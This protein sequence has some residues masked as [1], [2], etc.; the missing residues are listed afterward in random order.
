MEDN[1]KILNIDYYSLVN[2]TFWKLLKWFLDCVLN[3]GGDFGKINTI[4]LPGGRGSGKSM[5]VTLL[6]FIGLLHLKRPSITVMKHENKLRETIYAA[7]EKMAR[8]MGILDLVDFISRPLEIRLKTNEKKSKLKLKFF[9]VDKSTGLKSLEDAS[10]EGVFIVHIDEADQIDSQEDLDNILASV[11]G[12]KFLTI[13]TYNPPKSIN[14]WIHELETPTNDRIVVW[15]DYLT[16]PVDWLQPTFIQIAERMRDSTSEKRRRNYRW[17]YLGQRVSTGAEV[18]E[19][20]KDV[21]FTDED[22]RVFN[23]D[24]EVLRGI[25]FGHGNDP[26]V[27]LQGVY[28]EETMTLKIFREIYL[29]RVSM[30]LFAAKILE[31]DDGNGIVY[32][33]CADPGAIRQIKDRGVYNVQPVYKY[34]GSRDLGWDWL[35]LVNIEIDGVRCPNTLRETKKAEYKIDKN[36][37]LTS[38]FPEKDDHTIDTERYMCSEK[39]RNGYTVMGYNAVDD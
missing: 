14:H 18:F 9:G 35:S 26:S 12:S 7:A 8:K 32:A 4:V 21:R 30:E 33:D 15:S 28:I 3:K 19:T 11:R 10:G 13:I 31:I 27:Y 17:V 20:Y 34:S 6:K 37:N 38:E 16:V 5:F 24:Y 22:I 2:P 29:H 1:R 23:R 39:I 36:G 25:D